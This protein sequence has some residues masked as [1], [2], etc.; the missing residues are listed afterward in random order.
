MEGKDIKRSAIIQWG[1]FKILFL[2]LLSFSVYIP[3]LRAPFEFDDRERIVE[4]RSIRELSN[5]PAFFY[6]RDVM[7]FGGEIYRPLGDVTYAVDYNIWGYEPSGFHLTNILIHASASVALYLLLKTMFNTRS[8]APFWGTVLFACHPANSEAVIWV[9]GREDLLAAL[10]SILALAW[11][12]R[13]VGG[14]GG[15]Y[16]ILAAA[17]YVT[18]LLSKESAIAAP[19]LI[20]LIDFA[21]D[22]H[23]RQNLKIYLSY[24][25]FTLLYIAIR[26]I[27]LQQLSQQGYWGR[28]IIPTAYTMS[29]G[30]VY[31]IKLLVFPFNLCID[32]LSYPISMKATDPLVMQSIATLLILLMSGIYALRVKNRLWGIGVFWFFIAILPVSN[33]VPIKILIAERFLYLPSI[34]VI[35]VILSLSAGLTEKRKA[36]TMLGLTLLFAV[37]TLNR[38]SY[39][40]SSPKLWKD[41]AIKMPVNDRAYFNLASVYMEEGHFKE[42]LLANNEATRLRPGDPQGYANSGLIYAS[43]GDGPA[44]MREYDRALVIDPG[45][46][47]VHNNKGL[48]YLKDGM[49]EKAVEEFKLELAVHPNE[50]TVWNLYDA[51]IKAGNLLFDKGDLIGAESYY[52]E[53]ISVAEKS[54]AGYINLALVYKKLNR[55]GDAVKVYSELL[56]VRPDLSREVEKSIKELKED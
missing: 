51:S 53:A 24:L 44:A 42:A 30:L 17:A 45:I 25:L 50:R 7:P 16:G 18:A 36:A 46:I 40:L 27:V 47:N 32:Y 52:K 11:H 9:K 48:L 41:A 12:R 13:Y 43:L 28:G 8:S 2:G 55:H 23:T 14:K 15:K 3:A 35:L 10:F 49:P 1:F 38:E 19:L 4:N 54:E 21:L 5:I 31:Y 29:R 20:I 56:K 33:L 37:L 22:G 26:S 34:S 39:W 6:S